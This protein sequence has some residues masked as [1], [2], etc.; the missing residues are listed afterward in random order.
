MFGPGSFACAD[1]KVLDAW[2]V[3]ELRTAT[4]G[5]QHQPRHGV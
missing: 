1:S 2:V 4:L 5:N 3:E